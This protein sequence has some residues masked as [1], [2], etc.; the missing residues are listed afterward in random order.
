MLSD[1]AGKLLDG[2]EII[3]ECYSCVMSG[4]NNRFALK[5][6]EECDKIILEKR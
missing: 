5:F 2:S 1:Y 4:V 3:A 6:V